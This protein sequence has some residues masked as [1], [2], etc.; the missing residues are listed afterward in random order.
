VVPEN[1]MARIEW[2]RITDSGVHRMLLLAMVG[3][4]AVPLPSPRRSP[5]PLLLI[6]VRPHLQGRPAMMPRPPYD[7]DP[8]L[9]HLIM[10]LANT[11]TA[12][13][14]TVVV[15]AS[16]ARVTAAARRPRLDQILSSS[17]MAGGRG[18]A[19]PLSMIR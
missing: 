11:A 2:K 14:L 16:P 7:P 5:R 4:L 15:I 9:P 17:I 8:A 1:N 6:P 10:H 19:A 12:S 18:V 3:W 13:S